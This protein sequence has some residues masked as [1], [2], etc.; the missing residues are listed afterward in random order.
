MKTESKWQDHIRFI[1][2]IFDNYREAGRL[3][4]EP[5]VW[6]P[7][8]LKYPNGIK[9]D[10]I[11]GNETQYEFIQAE[12]N[13][14]FHRYWEHDWNKRIMAQR[15]GINIPFQEIRTRQHGE[16]LETFELPF[17]HW[18]NSN[19]PQ[20]DYQTAIADKKDILMLNTKYE[21]WRYSKRN[22]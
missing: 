17:Q 15:V 14:E 12:G 21:D 19:V 22:S 1:N 4:W 5:L 6:K 7:D 3:S 2:L 9:R 8:F 11:S 20:E 18:F 16:F 13:K 10:Y